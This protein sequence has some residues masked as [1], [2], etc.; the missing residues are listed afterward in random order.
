M[1]ARGWRA[2]PIH[3]DAKDRKISSSNKERKN[4]GKNGLSV[5]ELV[6]LL[7]TRDCNLLNLSDPCPVGTEECLA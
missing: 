1:S 4:I 2:G 5:I 7:V 6:V 3:T